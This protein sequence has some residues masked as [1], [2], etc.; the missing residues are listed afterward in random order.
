MN[1]RY[2]D[3]LLKIVVDCTRERATPARDG[4]G[5]SPLAATTASRATFRRAGGTAAPGGA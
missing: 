5:G 2:P 4:A 3:G 1:M